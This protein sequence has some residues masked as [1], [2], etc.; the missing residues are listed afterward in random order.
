[1]LSPAE[2][3][4]DSKIKSLGGSGVVSVMDAG[5]SLSSGRAVRAMVRR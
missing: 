4:I 2:A 3:A 1:M 5:M